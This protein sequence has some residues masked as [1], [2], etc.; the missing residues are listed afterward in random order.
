MRERALEQ[1][2]AVA[3]GLAAALWRW[4]LRRGHRALLL[5]RLAWLPLPCL[6]LLQRTVRADS[7]LK[8]I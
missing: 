1:V 2:L 8:V 7:A 3:A 4:L 5:L 6:R